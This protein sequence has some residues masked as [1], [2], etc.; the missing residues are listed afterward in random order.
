MRDVLVYQAGLRI[1]GRKGVQTSEEFRLWAQ[2]LLRALAYT[3]R[4]SGKILKVCEP[5]IT[6]IYNWSD[7]PWQ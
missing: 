5:Q 6:Q 3:S 1:A 7:L 2:D 4:S